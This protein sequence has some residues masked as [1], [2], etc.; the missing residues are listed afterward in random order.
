[1]KSKTMW[2]R[3]VFM[4][5]WGIAS[6]AFAANAEKGDLDEWVGLPADIASSAY[7]YRADRQTEENPP[8]AWI[9]LVQHA[10]LPFHKPVDVNAPAVKRALG[11]LLWEEVRPV[12]RVELSWAGDAKNR[13]SADQ[14]AL[15]Y[16][17]GTDQNPHTW[18]NPATITEAEKPE[19]SADGRTYVYTIPVDTWGLVV[20]VRGE[21]DASALAVPA[22]R[23]IVDEV[24]K[25]MDVEIEWGFDGD[26]AALAYDGRIEAYDGMIGNVRP[27]ADD[28][29]TAMTGPN[30]WRSVRHGGARRGLQLSLLY[31]GTSRW[32]REHPDR[33]QPDDVA[34]SII[35]LWTKSGS[36]SFR[37]S[38]L[39]QGPILAP[40]YGFF[41]RATSKSQNS[42][43][44][45]APFTMESAAASARDFLKELKGKGLKTVRQRVREHTEQNWQDAV[46]AMY[47]AQALPPH[48]EPPLEPAMQVEVP[49]ERMTAQWKLGAWH[50]LRRSVRDQNGKWSFND[51]PFG[52]LAAE[53]YQILRALDFQGLHKEAADGLDQWLR[54]PM[55]PKGAPGSHPDR[56]LGHFSDGRGCFTHAVGPEGV[57]GHM[58]G[59]HP[60]GPGIIMH[61]MNEHVRLTGDMDWLKVHAP[62]MKA[63]AEWILRQRHLFAENIPGGQ[64]LWC[65]GLQ[66]A[67]CAT[68]DANIM[69]AQFYLMRPTT[70]WPSNRWR[71]C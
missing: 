30:A 29:G 54:L 38:D 59:I 23:A 3:I 39:E 33:A 60:L 9:L 2:C 50:I 45:E 5:L 61:A 14:L 67:M 46:A 58:D 40:E 26:T 17:D 27:L 69:Y 57:G 42:V 31:L 21:K 70:G 48:P 68:T 13:P 24:W 56:P 71:N 25:K 7:S 55:E 34:R 51:Y 19:V 32:R 20:S 28:A 41:V 10:N 4:L 66:P 6:S 47:P 22:I 37:V 63:N 16:F 49:D 65:K 8:E 18:W 35:T 43:S 12:R 15:R 1:M 64:R 53:T 11:G 36:F 52:I 44:S 62:R